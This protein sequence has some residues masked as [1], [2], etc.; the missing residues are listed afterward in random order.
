GQ[1]VRLVLENTG[2]SL[3]DFTIE[4]ME[5][6]VSHAE[7]GSEDPDHADDH[8]AHTEAALHLALDGHAMGTLEF[9]P[10][11]PGEYVF[12]CTVEGHAQNGMTGTLIVTEA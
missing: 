7:G 9:T 3:H 4:E 6:H 11:E 8:E 1:S 12:L 2:L 5:A 10:E